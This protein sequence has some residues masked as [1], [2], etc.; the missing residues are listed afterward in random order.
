MR[1][2]YIV[3]SFGQ[4]GK[5][6]WA[7]THLISFQFCTQ[8]SPLLFTALVLLLVCASQHNHSSKIKEGKRDSFG[9]VLIWTGKGEMYVKFA[10]AR[11]NIFL[12]HPFSSADFL[13]QMTSIMS[14]GSG[15]ADRR[16]GQPSGDGGAAEPVL[17]HLEVLSKKSIVTFL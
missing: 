2:V 12:T 6:F 14:S 9:S 8:L 4:Q 10:F 15:V 16:A 7:Q 11:L 3:L 1:I 13:F 5:L 17:D